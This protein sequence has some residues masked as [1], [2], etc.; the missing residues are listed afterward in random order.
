MK[1]PNKPKASPIVRL[2]LGA[3]KLSKKHQSQLEAF[4]KMDAY[5]KLAGK[6]A[7][8]LRLKRVDYADINAAIKSQSNGEREL[9]NLRYRGVPVISEAR[10]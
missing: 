7:P 3:Y 8:C 1:D 4:D 9:S 6:H 10:S 2:D 5:M